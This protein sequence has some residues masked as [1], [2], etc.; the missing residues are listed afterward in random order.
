MIF[1]LVVCVEFYILT[2]ELLLCY[3]QAI[4]LPGAEGSLAAEYTLKVR[5]Q[6]SLKGL[7]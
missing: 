5:L 2:V 4:A 6:R 1:Y 3:H 7:S